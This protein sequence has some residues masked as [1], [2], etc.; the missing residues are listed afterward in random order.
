M[1]RAAFFVSP[2]GFGHAARACAVIAELTRQR[3]DLE[4]ELFTEV[5]HW[6]FA[7]SLACEFSYQELACDIGL[8]QTSPLIE[9]I[10]ATIDRLDRAWENRSEVTRVGRQLR[11]LECSIVMAD[12]SPLGLAAASVTSIPSVL[13]ENFTWDWIYRNYPSA[14]QRLLEHGR[15]LADVFSSAGLR[16]QAEPVCGESKD[17]ARVGPIA[18]RARVEKSEVRAILGVP[19]DEPMIVV[20]MGGVRWDYDIFS[21]FEHSDGAWIVVPGGSQ[22]ALERRGRIILLPFHAD[23]YHPDL[24]AAS[25][26]VVS[27]LGYSTVAEAYSAGAALI[28]I[29][30]P[31]FPESPVLATWAEE[32]MLAAEITEQRL[33]DGSWLEVVDGLLQR[34][35]RRPD[36]VNG[37]AE[38][39]EIILARFG[40]L[41]E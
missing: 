23:I 13:I 14:P 9:D 36:Q 34:P 10:S 17:S 40:S 5:P 19:S 20:S 26:V 4:F 3:S 2:H 31:L 21:D 8:V 37:A 11:E 30:R 29:G 1:K 24:V 25:D 27:K 22:R 32:H 12:I 28:Y 41:I 38:A 15:R 16:I 7:D 39:A 6:F 18:R 35:R 33:R